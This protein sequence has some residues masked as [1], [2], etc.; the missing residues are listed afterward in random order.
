MKKRAISLLSGGLDSVLA[1]KIMLEEGFEIVAVHFVSPFH[2]C[3]RKEQACADQAVRSA[4]ELG[5]ELIVMEKELDY[6]KVVENPKFGYGKNM[7]P[8]LDCRIYMLRRA[9]EIMVERGASFIVTGEVVGQRPMS[10]TKE[11]MRLIEKESHLEG[12]IVRP[13]SGRLLPPTIPEIEGI[14]DRQRLFAISGRGRKVQFGYAEKLGIR[15]FSHPAGGCLLTD[16]NFSRRIKDLF[17]YKKDYDMTDVALLRIGRHIRVNGDA[18]FVVGRN[19]GENRKLEAMHRPP[20]VLLSPVQFAGPRVLICGKATQQS[21]TIGAHILAYY[22]R[23][24]A[25]SVTVEV[26]GTETSLQSFPRVDL[27]VESYIM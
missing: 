12:L 1:T 8:C 16:P 9:K 20:Y 10:Q 25:P 27:D 11:R 4:K 23:Y 14:L 19:E 3:S 5:V 17:A 21:L 18:K 24:T 6:V 26:R 13:L 15:E 7:N 2:N 22:A